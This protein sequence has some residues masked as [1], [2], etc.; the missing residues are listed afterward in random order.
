MPAHSRYL[1]PSVGVDADDTAKSLLALSLL[2]QPASHQAFLQEFEVETHFR[3]YERERDP[4]FSAN[5]N[6]LAALLSQ[7]DVFQLARQI[8]K[9]ASFLSKT[10][11]ESSGAIDDKWVQSP[12]TILSS[13]FLIIIKIEP[14]EFL[15][16]NAHG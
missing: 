14:F 15:P 5:C 4:S 10:W 16:L 2:G 1:A 12:N 11:L 3:T 7:P 8:K 9:V 13:T 6:V